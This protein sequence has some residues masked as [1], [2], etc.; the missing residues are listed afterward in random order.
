MTEAYPL[1]WPPGWP[2]TSMSKRTASR[3][4]RNT[5]NQ[6]MQLQ[7]EL[8]RLGATN[9]IISSNVPVRQDGLPYS[10]AAK[11]RY[12]D[13]GVAVYF[14]LRGKPLS[15]AR[16]RYWTPWE[17][18][19]SLVLAIDAMRSIERHGGST[20]MERAF[21]G[22]AALPPPDDCWKILGID[23]EIITKMR[24]A[25]NFP[26]ECRQLIQ[27]FFRQAARRDHGNGG[28]MD[29]LVKARDEALEKIG[30]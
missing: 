14:K 1:A 5:Y 10:D 13:P 17:N 3:F 23:R 16:D 4:G 28:D 21:G 7:G 30:G 9:V 19:R 6:I 22:F 15:M 18:M 26:G 20:M 27:E 11:R 24:K 12:D 25:E 2:R 8:R 29:R